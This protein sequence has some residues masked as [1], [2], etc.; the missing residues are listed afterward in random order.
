LGLTRWKAVEAVAMEME[1]EMERSL[2][3]SSPVPEAV[4]R[5]RAGLR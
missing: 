5:S 1:M 4:W 2:Q 3:E